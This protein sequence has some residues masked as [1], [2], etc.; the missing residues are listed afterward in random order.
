MEPMSRM[1]VTRD[2]QII[3]TFLCLRPPQGVILHTSV[4][5]LPRHWS[6]TTYGG[7]PWALLLA[8]CQSLI[9]SSDSLSLRLIFMMT[10][11]L[12]SERTSRASSLEIDRVMSVIQTCFSTMALTDYC[13][14]LVYQVFWGW[15]FSILCTVVLCNCSRQNCM[16]RRTASNLTTHAHTHTHTNSS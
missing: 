7:S 11:F 8:F 14:F 13:R 3:A 15:H 4:K 6:R 10:F 12:S 1:C 9:E 5:H 2:L 16:V